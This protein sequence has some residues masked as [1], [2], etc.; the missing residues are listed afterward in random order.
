MASSAAVFAPTLKLTTA[1]IFK[2]LK[3]LLHVFRLWKKNITLLA[4]CRQ[5]LGNYFPVGR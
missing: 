2:I 4:S 1:C 5:V 3:L